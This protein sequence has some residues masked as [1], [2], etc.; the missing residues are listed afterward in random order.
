[1]KPTDC[2]RAS[3]ARGLGGDAEGL[4]TRPARG[5]T[6]PLAMA[7]VIAVCVVLWCLTAARLWALAGYLHMGWSYDP[8]E[9]ARIESSLVLV[10][11]THPSA[12]SAPGAQTR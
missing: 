5:R 1:M 10:E 11:S 8:E 3:E 7:L 2:D 6:D 9:A 4:G 12:G